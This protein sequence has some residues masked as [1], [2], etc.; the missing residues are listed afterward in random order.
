[1]EIAYQRAVAAD[2]YNAK[3]L[4]QFDL[5][6]DIYNQEEDRVK[7][8]RK[9]KNFFKVGCML[10]VGTT[11]CPLCTLKKDFREVFHDLERRHEAGEEMFLKDLVDAVL[12]EDGKYHP[13]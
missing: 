13:S 1:M 6:R 5:Y 9:K 7:R 10:C 8:R 12:K 4:R 2:P 11:F 3:I